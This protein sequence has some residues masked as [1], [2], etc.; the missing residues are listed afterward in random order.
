MNYTTECASIFVPLSLSV[1]VCVD[2]FQSISLASRSLKQTRSDEKRKLPKTCVCV[3]LGIIGILLDFSGLPFCFVSQQG[4]P[5][6]MQVWHR[7]YAALS[8]RPRRLHLAT[9]RPST[10]P[11]PSLRRGLHPTG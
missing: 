2:L 9:R 11:F 5:G 4:V 6:T 8:Y 3:T 10:F 7:R 1:H